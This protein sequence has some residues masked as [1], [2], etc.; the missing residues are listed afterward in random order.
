MHNF[1]YHILAALNLHN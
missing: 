1:N